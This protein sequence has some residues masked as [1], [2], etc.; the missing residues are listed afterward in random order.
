MKKGN[1]CHS[2]NLKA[3]RQSALLYL[4]HMYITMFYFIYPH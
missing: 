2:H 4:L 3:S 1:L